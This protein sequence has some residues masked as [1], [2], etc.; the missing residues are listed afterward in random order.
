MYNQKL[1]PPDT[2]QDFER[3]INQLSPHF[4]KESDETDRYGISGQVQWGVD[5]YH[6]SS[7]KA[8]QS[9]N[10]QKLTFPVVLEELKKTNKFPHS[11][12]HYY[13]ATAS[14]RNGRL[15]DAVWELNLNREEAELFKITVVF[16]D[17]LRDIINQNQNLLESYTG[18][19]GTNSAL[20]GLHQS[21]QATSYVSPENRAR[22]LIQKYLPPELTLDFLFNYDFST[23]RV[24][25]AMFNSL[26]DMK[27]RLQDIQVNIDYSKYKPDDLE[28]KAFLFR[29]N[30]W[31]NAWN[32]LSL[33]LPKLQDFCNCISDCTSTEIG[34]TDTGYLGI[35]DSLSDFRPCPSR[36][37]TWQATARAL[38]E[39]YHDNFY[40]GNKNYSPY[41][42]P[43]NIDLL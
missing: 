38:G 20:A 5:H 27:Y 43:R 39:F 15:Q 14:S 8:V 30:E 40:T 12:S 31:V 1:Q 28:V 4:I 35:F 25:V 29:N 34:D 13:I 23:A 9:K 26:L 7:R 19:L 36:T 21:I 11:I 3:L 17:D 32:G 41:V 37:N 2:D 24:P 33:L 22:E 16:W 6:Q 42:Q 18:Q 10:V